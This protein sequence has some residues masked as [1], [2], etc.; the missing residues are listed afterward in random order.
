MEGRRRCRHA[1]VVSQ[2]GSGVG[3]APVAVGKMSIKTCATQLGC[4]CKTRVNV[5]T[6]EALA[7]IGTRHGAGGITYGA[8]LARA[9]GEP[10]TIRLMG[11]TSQSELNRPYALCRHCSRQMKATWRARQ[12]SNLRPSA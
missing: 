5:S 12:D 7:A 10:W 11:R 4:A 9:E 3:V 8:E 1:L 2:F 6:A